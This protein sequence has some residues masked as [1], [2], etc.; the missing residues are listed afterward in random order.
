MKKVIAL[1]AIVVLSACNN[2]TSPTPTSDST[3]VDSSK[4]VVDS[5]KVD[6]TKN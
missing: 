6:S 3:K 2:S 4:T 1:T 5:I